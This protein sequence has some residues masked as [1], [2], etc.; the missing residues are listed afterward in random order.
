[1]VAVR[2]ALDGSA[3]AARR[4]DDALAGFH[5]IAVVKIDAEDLG[6]EVLESGQRTIE[7]DRPVIAIE[8]TTDVA[9][10]RIRRL[11]QPLGYEIVGQFCWTPTWLWVPVPDAGR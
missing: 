3:I 7:R 9:C 8:A 1:M 5:D 6:V 11:L 2:P 4:L 10:S